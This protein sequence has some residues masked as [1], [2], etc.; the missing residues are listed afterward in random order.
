MFSRPR[1]CHLNGQ[2]K[3]LHQEI[4]GDPEGER[5]WCVSSW[6]FLRFLVVMTAGLWYCQAHQMFH[7][8][9]NQEFIWALLY[10]NPEENQR[11][12]T[13]E[14]LWHWAKDDCIWLVCNE[15]ATWSWSP[16]HLHGD[17]L[18][19]PARAQVEG[20]LG[21]DASEEGGVQEGKAPPCSHSVQGGSTSCHK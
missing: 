8:I 21:W 12:W 10:P 18:P 4:Q 20:S 16:S 7:G 6:S 15:A 14:A 1:I 17:L 2:R 19:V 5:L 13:N 11:R 9:F 3:N